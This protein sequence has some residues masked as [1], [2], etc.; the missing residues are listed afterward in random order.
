ML[1]NYIKIA[2]KV[3]QRRK[4]FTFVSLFG[5]SITLMVLMVLTAFSDHLFSPNYPEVN[6]D[7]CLYVTYATMSSS[8]WGGYNNGASGFHFIDKYV[9]SMKTPQKIGM[10]S[11]V[12]KRVDAFY[13]DRRLKLFIKTTDATFWDI[14]AFEFLAGKPF[15]QQHLEEGGKVAVISEKTRTG[16]FGNRTD[17]LGEAIE[18][19]LEKY[20]IIGV[21][22]GVPITQVLTSADIY[23]PYTSNTNLKANKDLTSNSGFGGIVLANDASEFAA[24]QAEF[25]ELL[26]KVAL[27]DGWDYFESAAEPLL[28]N[29]IHSTVIARE[30]STHSFYLFL[31]FFIFLFMALPAINLINI[32]VSRIM[33]RS[34][35]IGVRKA[36]GATSSTLV[37]QFIVENIIITLIGGVIGVLLSILAI[38]YLNSSGFI[39]DLDLV[40]NLKVLW[41]SFLFCLF[42]GLM[43]GVLPA[44]RMSK[45]NVVSALKN[46]TA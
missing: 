37:F 4:F 14:M 32:N 10:A 29:F 1:K 43:S 41:I 27:P 22:K 30:V 9:K 3:L 12:P 6:K 23:V 42:F 46:G 39:P 38:H 2:W 16:Y 13:G 8:K 33:E 26:P 24:I 17:V 44:F 36:F 25:A 28:E 5:I 7:K 45:V 35:E 18:I 11:L 15:N 34:S 19:G 31:G 20:K 40:L 21:V